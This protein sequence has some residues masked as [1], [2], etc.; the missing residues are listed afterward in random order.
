MSG[1]NFQQPINTPTDLVEKYATGKR[2][3]SRAE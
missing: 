1:V 3:F 2:D